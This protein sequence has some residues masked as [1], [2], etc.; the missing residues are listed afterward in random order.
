M[1]LQFVIF[2]Y[3]FL[4][5]VFLVGLLRQE[6]PWHRW[7]HQLDQNEV[8]HIDGNAEISRVWVTWTHLKSPLGEPNPVKQNIELGRTLQ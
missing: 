2:I 5:V 3:I 4:C 1:S 7:S 8:S 6:T